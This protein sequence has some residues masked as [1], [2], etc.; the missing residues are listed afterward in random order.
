MKARRDRAGANE[1]E[2]R[3]EKKKKGKAVMIERAR[4]LASERD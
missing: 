4:V 1:T 3:G 2:K